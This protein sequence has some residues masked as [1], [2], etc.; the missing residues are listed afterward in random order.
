MI[1]A[2]LF[3]LGGGYFEDGTKKF[4]T[5]LSQKTKKL[6]KSFILSSEKA[7]VQITEKIKFQVQSFL[8]GHQ[9]NWKIRLHLTSLTIFGLSNIQKIPVLEMSF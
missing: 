3:D 7:K 6:S 5:L 9:N 2:I 1:K 8:V 4:L